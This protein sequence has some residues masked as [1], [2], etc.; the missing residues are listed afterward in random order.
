M[1]Q[2]DYV[3]RESSKTRVYRPVCGPLLT[4]PPLKCLACAHCARGPNSLRPARDPRRGPACCSFAAAPDGVRRR[5]GPAPP[6]PPAAQ[7]QDG[8]AAARAGEMAARLRGEMAAR[9]RS[10]GCEVAARLSRCCET[11]LLLRGCAAS[12][13]IPAVSSASRPS[14]IVARGDGDRCGCYRSGRAHCPLIDNEVGRTFS[15]R[16]DRSIIRC[17][18]LSRYKDLALSASY[19]P[20][21]NPSS[22]E[23]YSWTQSSEC[24]TDVDTHG[25]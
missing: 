8:R 23:Q 13:R 16:M 5:W 17:P 7:R 12:G 3:T 21:S 19:A 14:R 20:A 18:C 9:L 2:A 22:V 1:L 24:H 25:S 15:L 10:H 4:G 6:W 11:A